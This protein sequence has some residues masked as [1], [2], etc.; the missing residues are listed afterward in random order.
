[1]TAMAL[2]ATIPLGVDGQMLSDMPDRGRTGI[3]VILL[4]E[5]HSEDLFRSGFASAFRSLG[6]VTL[7]GRFEEY[8]VSI[9]VGVMCV[10]VGS[11]CDR[12]S[13][14][15]VSTSVET[16]VTPDWIYAAVGA[17]D[18]EVT[19]GGTPLTWAAL[20]N[21]ARVLS[22]FRSTELAQTAVWGRNT[23]EGAI[24]RLVATIDTQC[25]ETVRIRNRFFVAQ[26]Q[27]DWDAMEQIGGTLA[28]RSCRGAP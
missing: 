9:H 3:R 4:V 23:Y 11:E 8:D 16:P 18:A 2:V 13:A 12:P 19:I 26:D 20:E 6:D 1:M 14:W 21:A 25:L 15:S 24:Q 7:V 17:R 27:G 22:A 5:G 10:G 28:D